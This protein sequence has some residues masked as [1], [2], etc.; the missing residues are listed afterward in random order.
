[1][2]SVYINNV[3]KFMPNDAVTNEEIEDYLGYIGGKKSKAKKVVLRSNGIKSRYYVLEKGTEKALFSNAQ[4]TANAIKKLENEKFSLDSV[5]C[6]SCG[7]TTPDQLMPN[8]TLMV[9]GELGLTE[10]ETLSAS[11]ICLSG[12][13][14]LKYAYYGIKCGDLENVVSTGSEVVSPTLSA[15]NFKTESDHKAV[16]QN[17]GIAFEKDFLRW[18]LS[19]GAGAMLLQNKP[20]EEGLSLK[21]DWI[22]ILSY[23]G[24]MP[25][26]MYSGCEVK[27]DELKG[28][29]TFT[30][31]EIME[32]S[33]L[34]IAQDV[35]LLN[36]NIIEYTVT[37]PIE[38]IAKKRDLKE[39]EISYFLPHYS[40]TFFRDKVY[41][42]MKKGG[43]EIPFEKWFTNL[44]KCGN[45]GSASIYIM[46]EELFNSNKLSKGEKILCYIPES[47]RFSTSFMML[48]VV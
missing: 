27:G 38:K 47:G 33:L 11:G 19:D 32:K 24:E 28:F 44:T 13:N 39:E 26:C 5:D 7:T 4:I 25:T 21:I 3:Q 1:M 9:Q 8:H 40:S 42:G 2:N 30:Q 10:I 22:D 18:M 45:T 37:K 23:A 15:K 29:R 34:T 43:L 20:N 48:E 17:P 46:L 16:E 6:L 41:E 14:A 36:E 12:I 35:K 31:E